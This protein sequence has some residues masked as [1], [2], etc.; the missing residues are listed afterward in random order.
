MAVER[1][2]PARPQGVGEARVN[3]P[4]LIGNRNQAG[5]SGRETPKGCDRI[6]GFG[7]EA[8][9]QLG[10]IGARR[11]TRHV[12]RIL[13]GGGA[14][15]QRLTSPR[16]REGTLYWTP[17][18][19]RPHPPGPTSRNHAGRS[20][21][22]RVLRRRF[23]SR[24][25]TDEVSLT[26]PPGRPAD[27]GWRPLRLL[28]PLAWMGVIAVLSGSLFGAE[29]TGAWLLPLLGR[30]VPWANAGVLQALHAI[31]R[32]L[33]HVVEYGVLA[34]LWLRALA[35]APRAAGWALALSALYAG[36]D[37]VR[38]SLAPN[39]TP[40]ALDVLF[41]TAGAF[42]ALAC[43]T[44]P[45]VL[46]RLGVRVARWAAWLL[47]GG[48]LVALVLDWSLGLP[49]WDLVGAALGAAAVAWGLGRRGRNCP[50]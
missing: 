32:K 12:A 50:R 41:D 18:A 49:A 5:G 24:S 34:A 21:S 45:G 8:V 9:D 13:G 19:R 36:I 6:A 26:A 30:L 2:D 43:L 16:P 44:G 27:P 38:Q 15:C 29:Q 48:S 1:L 39:R 20:P 47:A 4:R 46:V 3:D 14:R 28:P 11:L 17:G 31:L 22:G 35:P 7:H 42:L 10:E 33:A 25:P 23:P 40:S 37:E